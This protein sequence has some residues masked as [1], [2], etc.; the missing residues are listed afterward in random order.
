MGSQFSFVCEFV[1]VIIVIIIII[2]FY[3]IFLVCEQLKEAEENDFSSTEAEGDRYSLLSVS[4]QHLK[5]KGSLH[6]FHL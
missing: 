5:S 6:T 2:L 3:F 1:V 4:N